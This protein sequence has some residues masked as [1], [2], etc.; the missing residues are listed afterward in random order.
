MKVAV[1]TWQ[2]YHGR[3]KGSIGSS[4]I[5]GEWL[6][7]HWPEAFLWQNGK[8]SD[9]IIYQKSF[10]P[11][12]MQDFPGIKIYD[13]C[14]PDWLKNDIQLKTIE[15][16]CDAITCSTDT[17]TKE[18]KNLIET[19]P[20]LTIPDRIDFDQFPKTEK[21]HKERAKNIVWFGYYHNIETLLIHILPTLSKYKLDLTIISNKQFLPAENYRINITFVEW[22]Q[23]TAYEIIRQHDFSLN[24]TLIHREFKYKSNN[25]TLISWALGLP[26]A[27]TIEELERFINPIERTKEIEIRKKELSEKWNIELSVQQYKNLINQI[28]ENRKKISS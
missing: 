10:W 14:D 3:K 25:K 16:Y 17:L 4:I 12:H 19:I 7:N 5:R 23:E 11:D 1:L 18:I 13:I 9:V 20:V 27:S 28:Y 26:S 24:P 8:Y 22:E 15:K 2:K 21:E 6:V